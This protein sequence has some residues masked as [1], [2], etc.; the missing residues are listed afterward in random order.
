MCCLYYLSMLS[1]CVY[2]DYTVPINM[3]TYAFILYTYERIQG[4]SPTREVSTPS[5]VRTQ[6]PPGTWRQ[7]G[8]GRASATRVRSSNCQPRGHSWAFK[9]D[10]DEGIDINT[11][12][13]LDIDIDIGKDVDIGLDIDTGKD[14]DIDIDSSSFY[15]L[16]SHF[17]GRGKDTS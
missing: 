12:I 11:D 1:I 6:G 15:K 17:A 2:I 7:V 10:V 5:G 16:A 13:G 8:P 4:N 3:Y 9:G 14:I